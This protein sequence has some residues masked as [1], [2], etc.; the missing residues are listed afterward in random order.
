MILDVNDE[1]PS[2]EKIRAAVRRLKNGRMQGVDGITP[3]ILKTSVRDSMTVL[4]E[5]LPQI[6]SAQKV[7]SDWTKGTIIKLF[8]N[9][10][11]ACLWQL[12]MH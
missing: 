1:P 4:V 11:H 9:R 10:R 12:G 5:L 6:W 3:E 2:Q 7:P 8:K